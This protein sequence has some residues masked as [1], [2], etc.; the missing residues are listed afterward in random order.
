MV[1]DQLPVVVIDMAQHS[2]PEHKNTADTASSVFVTVFFFLIF[3]FA[4]PDQEVDILY[5]SRI[6]LH[7]Q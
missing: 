3:L 2:P 7:P 4:L 1:W 5:L 6:T